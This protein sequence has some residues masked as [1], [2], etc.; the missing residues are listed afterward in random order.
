MKKR[1]VTKW[2]DTKNY[3]VLM[4]IFILYLGIK[5]QLDKVDHIQI[6][7]SK[8]TWFVPYTAVTND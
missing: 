2:I 5:V 1:H 8:S 6:V 3:V 7:D 4:Q